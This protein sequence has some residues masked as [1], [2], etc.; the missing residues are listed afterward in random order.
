MTRTVKITNMVNGMVSVKD[1]ST[2]VNRIWR[3]RG[4]TSA[5]PY[6]TVEA[7]LWQDGFLRLIQ[8]GVLY[9]ENL[10]DKQDLGLEPIEATEPTNILALTELQMKNLLTSTPITVFKKELSKYPKVQVD[11]LIEYAI[12]NNLVDTE[13]CAYLKQITGKDIMLA[14]SRREEDRRQDELEKNRQQAYASEGRRI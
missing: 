9:I 14:I 5:L 12:E 4:Q 2:G 8:S 1:P 3:K 7:L 13:K 6:E 11:N 10:K